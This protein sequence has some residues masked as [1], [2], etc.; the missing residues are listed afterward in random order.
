MTAMAPTT[1]IATLP[2]DPRP[3]TVSAAVSVLAAAFRDG[4][5][6]RWLEPDAASRRALAEAYFAVIVDEVLHLGDVAVA[7]ASAGRGEVP[8]W[9]PGGRL[10]GVALWS[11]HL[12]AAAAGGPARDPAR[13]P[14]GEAAPAESSLRLPAEVAARLAVLRELL[15][16]RRPTASHHHLAYLAVHPHRRCCGIGSALLA[17]RHAVLDALGAPAYLEADDPRNR[18][19]YLRHGYTAADPVVPP[20]GP[21]IWPMWRDPRPGSQPRGGS[22]GPRPASGRSVLA[23]AGPD[24]VDHGALQPG[25]PGEFRRGEPSLAEQDDESVAHGRGRLATGVRDTHGGGG[26]LEEVG[27]ALDLEVRPARGP[28]AVE[29]G[30]GQPVDRELGLDRL[31]DRLSGEPGAAGRLRLRQSP[32][33]HRRDHEVGPLLVGQQAGVPVGQPGRGDQLSD[34][35][36]HRPVRVDATHD[37]VHQPPGRPGESRLPCGRWAGVSGRDARHGGGQDSRL[38]AVVAGHAARY[39][40][41][42]RREGP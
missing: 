34:L 11:P 42:R 36:V 27:R 8:A 1:R 35:T 20:D 41:E 12:P 9:H 39:R 29:L 37:A 40:S 2:A 26:V 4:A 18:D 21:P 24:P 25:P 14:A 3:Q 15:A 6:A 38:E 28:G 19:L 31:V 5:V 7:T 13:D 22:R 17:R 10:D 23:P 30:P 16:A 32:V 33:E